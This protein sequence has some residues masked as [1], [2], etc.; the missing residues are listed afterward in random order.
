MPPPLLPPGIPRNPLPHQL[1]QV[2]LLDGE[3][4]PPGVREHLARKLRRTGPELAAGLVAAALMLAAAF[5]AAAQ[6]YPSKP[7]RLIVPFGAGGSADLL[8]RILATHMQ[9]KYNVPFVVENRAGAGGQIA[10]QA[11]KTAAP[12]GKTLFLSHDHTISILPLF[13]AEPGGT[14]NVRSARINGT[15]KSTSSARAADLPSLLCSGP[16]PVPVTAWPPAW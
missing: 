7:I 6:T 1:V 4:A 10:A 12:D 9:V 8:A 16:S 11:L 15:E 14:M 5:G 3:P 2:A 13:T